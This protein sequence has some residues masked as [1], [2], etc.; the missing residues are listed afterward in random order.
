MMGM[1]G[2]ARV[3]WEGWSWPDCRYPWL[4]RADRA[5]SRSAMLCSRIQDGFVSW[6]Y[7]TTSN[8]WSLLLGGKILMLV[9][10]LVDFQPTG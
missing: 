9:L 6:L 8:E 1:G 4:E 10:V 5:G 7:D 3:W 2:I